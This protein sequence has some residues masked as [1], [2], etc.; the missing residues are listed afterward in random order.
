MEIITNLQYDGYRHSLKA[1][2]KKHVKIMLIPLMHHKT[3]HHA[4]NNRNMIDAISV[5][6]QYK[7]IPGRLAKGATTGQSTYLKLSG[8][9][10]VVVHLV[11]NEAGDKLCIIDVNEPNAE[12][13][14]IV[15]FVG[16]SKVFKHYITQLSFSE[17]EVYSRIRH[18]VEDDEE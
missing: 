3:V 13:A 8:G 4:F 5:I 12:R 16:D 15:S 2:V 10:D 1:F 14:A 7:W 6:M 18:L 11:I 17:F 9:I